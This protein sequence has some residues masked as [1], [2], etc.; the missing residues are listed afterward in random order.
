MT[1]TRSVPDL[2]EYSP[3][4]NQHFRDRIFQRIGL[5]LLILY[6]FQVLGGL[7]IH[8]FKT[9]KLFKGRRPPQN[10]VHAILGLTI[11]ALAF[12][13]VHL[14]IKTEWAEALGDDSTVPRSALRAWTALIVVR[15]GPTLDVI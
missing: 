6:L 9:P 11:L 15:L 14:G 12:Y 2:N 7:V 10:Y 13:Q 8:Y 1:D 4:A 5:A 3:N